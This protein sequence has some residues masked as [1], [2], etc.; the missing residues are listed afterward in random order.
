M[1]LQC[2]APQVLFHLP[3]SLLPRGVF[4][5]CAVVVC[6]RCDERGAERSW[7]RRHWVLGRGAGAVCGRLHGNWKFRGERVQGT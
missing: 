3:W 2:G 7:Q 4:V 1:Q 6:A 5:N